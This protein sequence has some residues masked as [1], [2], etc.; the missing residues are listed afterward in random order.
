MKKITL[1]ILASFAIGIGI[2]FSVGLLVIPTNTTE[3]PTEGKPVVESSESSSNIENEK[4]LSNTYES[5]E[6][7]ERTTD[8]NKEYDEINKVAMTFISLFYT[9]TKDTSYSEKEAQLGDTL[10]IVGKRNLLED[11]SYQDGTDTAQTVPIKTKNYVS[12][13]S[14]TG[15][16]RVMSFMIYQTKYMDNTPTNAQTIVQ[17]ELEKNEEDVWQVNDAILRLLNQSMPDS[18]FS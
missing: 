2:G 3:K 12:F 14:V 6:P 1:F 11:Y 18:Y 10:S 13:D 4:E 9:N 8:N 15:T 5:M 16:A 7:V 17:I